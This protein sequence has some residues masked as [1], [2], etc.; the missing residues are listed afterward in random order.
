[1]SGRTIIRRLAALFL[2]LG[3]LSSCA[4]PAQVESR[5]AAAIETPPPVVEELPELPPEP[6]V[7]TLAVCGDVMSH[8]PVTNDAWDAATE[9]YD[10][11]PILRSVKPLVEQADYAVANLETTFAGGPKYS[12]FP[13]F[14][15]PD[16]L[17]DGLA[18]TGFDLL[19]TANNHCMDRGF[20]GLCRTLDVLDERGLAHVGTSRTQEEADANVVV[21][22]VG[23][24]SVAFL[25]FT[26]GTNGLPLE[27]PF[28]VNLFNTDYLTT[29]SQLDETRLLGALEQAKAL[30]PDLI[31]VMIHWG[32]EYKTK[33]NAYQERVAQFLFDHGADIVLGG[34][35]HVLQPMEL[36]TL[37][38]DDGERQG[39][40]CYSLGNFT[41]SQVDP[42]TDTTVVLELTL[43]RDNVTGAAEVADYTYTPMLMRN[44]GA[45]E[46]ERFELLDVYA[47]LFSGE[48]CEVPEA[49][50]AA[51]EAC[52]SILGTEHDAHPEFDINTP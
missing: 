21:A 25:G 24:I 52:R 7:A 41:S 19:L 26:Y 36:R 48:E 32:I 34:H 39:F 45:G 6:T 43:V 9:T 14:N 40:V 18:D 4:A 37:A 15:S 8:M 31:A 29:I 44:R 3:L 5:P 42:L 38:R 35:S 11:R 2:L 28:S 50:R 13:Y 46:A 10:Y 20:S 12:G 47:E 23:G 30:E 27:A 51:V 16:G 33:Q 49:C 22:D 1:M 17:A